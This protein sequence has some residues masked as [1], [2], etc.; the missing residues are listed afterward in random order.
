MAGKRKKKAFPSRS[1]SAKRL[2]PHGLYTPF[3]DLDQQLTRACPTAKPE[4]PPLAFVGKTVLEPVKAGD[5][6]ESLFLKAMAGVI[7]LEPGS[8]RRVPPPSPTQSPPRFLSLEEQEVRNHLLRLVEGELDF[9]I[10]CSDE[11]IDGAVTGLSPKVL[12]KLRQGEFSYQGHLDL[13]RMTRAE[14]REAATR[15]ILDSF[16]RGCRCVLVVCGRGLNSLDKEPVLKHSLVIWLTQA[17]L[18]RVVLA[19]ASAR[20]YDGGAGA[21]YVLLRRNQGKVCF[22]VPA[23]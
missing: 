13:H 11:Y 5:E 23:R 14:A 22:S 18:K 20:S 6:D 19:F 10:C 12:K 16:A 2:G 15:F 7:P 9:E 4:P 8:R 21:F 1:P 17:P 3:A